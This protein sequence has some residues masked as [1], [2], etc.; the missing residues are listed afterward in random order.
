MS[1]QGMKYK[2]FL[3]KNITNMHVG[4]GDSTF[5]VV[6]KLVQRDPVTNYPAIYSSSLKGALREYCQNENFTDYVFGKDSDNDT[7]KTSSPGQY[8]FFQ[9]NLLALPVRSN[10]KPYFMATTPSVLKDFIN[11]LK[12]FGIQNETEEFKKIRDLSEIKTDDDKVLIREETKTKIEE[13]NSENNNNIPEFSAYLG[14]DIVLFSETNFKELTKS[15]PVI[16]RNNLE[17]G[18]S[19][20]LWYEEIVPRQS[21]FYF[22]SGQ[23]E[24]HGANF[25]QKL[26]ADN[27]QIG[28]NASIGYGFTKISEI[29]GSN[30]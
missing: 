7:K 24:K 27:I 14:S 26:E 21:R 11:T 22:I 5:G 3:I 30:G 20:N 28:G 8:R 1:Y 2:A 10:K 25:I 17:N 6:D 15:L 4:S 9:A 29:G 12:D 13:W 19:T 18:Q 16:A 23:G